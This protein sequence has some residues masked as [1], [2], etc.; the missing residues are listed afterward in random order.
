MTKVKIFLSVE[1]EYTEM[2]RDINHWIESEHP[3]IISIQGNIAPQTPS[4]GGMIKDT[5]G[6]SDLFVIVLYEAE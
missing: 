6:S 2:E 5:F 3:K 1:S 4:S